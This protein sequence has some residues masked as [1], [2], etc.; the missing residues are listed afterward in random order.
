MKKVLL[1]L[2]VILIG[3]FFVLGFNYYKGTFSNFQNDGYVIETKNSSKYYFQN[4]AEYK[5][6]NAKDLV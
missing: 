2:G 3:V 1:F 4:N 6:Y 5:V